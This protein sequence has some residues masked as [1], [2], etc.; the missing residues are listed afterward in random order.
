MLCAVPPEP[1]WEQFAET[2]LAPLLQQGDVRGGVARLH[3]FRAQHPDDVNALMT[4]GNLYRMA[5]LPHAAIHALHYYSAVQERQR[6]YAPAYKAQ[7]E[8]LWQMGRIEAAHDAVKTALYLAGHD[9]S[10]WALEEKISGQTPYAPFPVPD[11]ALYTGHLFGRSLI[12]PHELAGKPIG[13][14]ETVFLQMARALQAAG[15]SVA[16]FGPFPFFANDCGVPCHGVREFLLYQRAHRL[17]CCIV[18]RHYE[19]FFHTLNAER[20]IFWLHD[21]VVPSYRDVYQHIDRQVHEYWILSRYQQRCYETHCGLPSHK[22][23]QT[24]NAIE[25]AWFGERVPLSGRVPYQLV[26]CSRPERG[27]DLLLEVYPKLRALFPQVTLT[28]CF[29]TGAATPAEDPALRPFAQA[30]AQPGIRLASVGKTELI[31]LLQTSHLMLYPNSSDLETSCLA[32]IEA[33]AAGLPIVTSD[34]GC[35]AET[36]SDGVAGVVLPWRANR[37]AMITQLVEASAALLRDPVRWDVLSRGGYAAGQT[38]HNAHQ[39]AQQWI[40]RLDQTTA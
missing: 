24:T 33:Q 40:E 18:S 17:P 20:R 14:S 10:L 31:R 36:V 25:P 15:K 9:D 12:L 23:W 35:L 5:P 13:G 39:V 32:A 22:F 34:R 16:L 29:Y 8:L 6:S 27:L 28:I 37:E 38:K 2:T 26:Y 3:Q 1:T 4:L 21:I 30:L 7:A 11:I 19:P